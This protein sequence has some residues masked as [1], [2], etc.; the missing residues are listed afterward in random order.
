MTRSIIQNQDPFTV[1]KQMKICELHD[2]VLKKNSQR[3]VITYE[4]QREDRP[5]S[6][7]TI[8]MNKVVKSQT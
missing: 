2:K 3:N 5:K 1:S 7:K 6:R 4:T 8:Y